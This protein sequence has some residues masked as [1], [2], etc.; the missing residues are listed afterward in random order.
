MSR[1]ASKW[2]AK[3]GLTLI[4]SLATLAVTLATSSERIPRNFLLVPAILL[5]ILLLSWLGPPIRRRLEAHSVRRRQL[6]RILGSWPGFRR[7]VRALREFYDPALGTSVRHVL[8]ET[9]G[10]VEPPDGI[11]AQELSLWERVFELLNAL[12]FNCVRRADR[13]P[14]SI[15]DAEKVTAD[16]RHLAKALETLGFPE[17]LK[18]LPAPQSSGVKRGEFLEAYAQFMRGYS[19]YCREANEGLNRPVFTPAP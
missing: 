11:T 15:E 16:F 12:S 7:R 5:A 9:T 4:V 2:S 8:Q 10:W 14:R 1:S 3:D 17:R 13:L 18:A 19:D 6:R